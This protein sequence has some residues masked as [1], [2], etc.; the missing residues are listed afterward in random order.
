M[1]CLSDFIYL[2]LFSFSQIVVHQ[3]VLWGLVNTFFLVDLT[4]MRQAGFVLSV[5][6]VPLLINSTDVSLVTQVMVDLN[7]SVVHLNKQPQT[8]HTHPSDEVHDVDLMVN[9]FLDAVSFL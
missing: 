2:R 3:T 1:D 5:L 4:E 8:K 7:F 6:A 9:S